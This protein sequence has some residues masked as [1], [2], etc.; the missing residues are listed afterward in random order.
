MHKLYRES[1]QIEGLRVEE[2]AAIAGIGRTVVFELIRDGSLPAR[3]IGKATKVLRRD[4]MN[5]LENLPRAGA[6]AA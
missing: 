5:Y 6:S 3:K 4:L 2:A 1:L